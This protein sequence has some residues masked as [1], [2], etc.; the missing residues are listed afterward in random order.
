LAVAQGQCPL[1]LLS[2]KFFF[3]RSKS[4]FVAIFSP[5]ELLSGRALRITPNSAQDAAEF[6]NGELLLRTWLKD[7]VL[8]VS[9]YSTFSFG[10]HHITFLT[11]GSLANLDSRPVPYAVTHSSISE[12]R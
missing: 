2:G 7:R 10:S 12:S 6:R 8:T 11:G 9:E 3:N 5:R 4:S 1:Q